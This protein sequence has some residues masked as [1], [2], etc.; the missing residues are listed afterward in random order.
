M[1]QTAPHDPI[2]PVQHALKLLVAA[3]QRG[4]DVEAHVLPL[5]E[6][7]F[8]LRALAGTHGQWPA[9]AARWLDAQFTL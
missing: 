1:K 2:V 5:A 9:L 3:Q 7:G 8:A 4:L 6:H